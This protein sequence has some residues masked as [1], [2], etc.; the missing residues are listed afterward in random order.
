MW[1]KI[2]S[3]ALSMYYRAE[4]VI[5]DLVITRKWPWYKI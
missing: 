2:S 5:T 4:V 3:A 1:W